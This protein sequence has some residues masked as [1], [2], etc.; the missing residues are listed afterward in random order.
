MNINQDELICLSNNDLELI[1]F[2]PPGYLTIGNTLNLSLGRNRFLSATCIG[3]G[4]ESIWLCSEDKSGEITDLVCV[5]N[6]DYDG[7]ITIDRLKALINWF[8]GI[9][10]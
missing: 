5:H 4:N 7:F 9:T 6:Y 10:P 8:R 1:G 2:E 3:Q